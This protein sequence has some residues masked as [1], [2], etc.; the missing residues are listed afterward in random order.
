MTTSLMYDTRMNRVMSVLE[1]ALDVGETH[2][3]DACR[4]I[5]VARRKGW[6]NVNRNDLEHVMDVY[7]NVI[8]EMLAGDAP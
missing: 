3:V 5:I 1:S 2:T 8:R 6:G 7:E 4:R